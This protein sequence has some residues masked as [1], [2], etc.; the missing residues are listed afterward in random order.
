MAP[1]VAAPGDARRAA[2]LRAGLPG[3]AGGPGGVLDYS[4]QKVTPEVMAALFDYAREAELEKKVAAMFRGEAINATEGRPVL[5]CALRAAPGSSVDGVDVVAEVQAVLA[6]IKAF[7]EKV[8]RVE[9]RHGQAPEGR[10]G[11]RHRRELPRPALRAHRPADQ[12]RLR[13]P[14]GE[15]RLHALR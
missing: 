8:R 15:G 14:G 1:P 2:Q 7:S 5:H 4:R 12:H 10:G 13:G 9:G 11:D 3:P 6:K